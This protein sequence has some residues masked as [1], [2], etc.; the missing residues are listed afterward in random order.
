MCSSEDDE[1]DDK[2]YKAADDFRGTPGPSDAAPL[3][4]EEEADQRTGDEENTQ[5][6]HQQQLL[7]DS[8]GFWCCGG[9]RSE[10]QEEDEQGESADRE[11]DI[12]AS[13][14]QP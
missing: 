12:E 9:R 1:N 2:A 14:Y 7:P 5:R 6:I 4:C 8:R 13:K 10:E 11:V 3:Y